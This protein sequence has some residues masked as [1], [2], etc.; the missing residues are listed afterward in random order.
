[1]DGIGMDE[2]DLEPEETSSGRR[3]Y[4]LRPGGFELVE[5]GAKILCLE[6][7]MVHPGSAAREEAA[8]R[9]VGARRCHELEPALA[10][11]QR[12]RLDPLPGK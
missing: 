2:C 1:M 6:R 10:D 4:Q 11:E 5:R 8:D 7:D 9:G 12:R 3:V